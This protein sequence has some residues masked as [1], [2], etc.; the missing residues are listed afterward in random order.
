[1]LSL[2]AGAAS[3][4]FR[5]YIDLLKEGRL[6][7]AVRCWDFSAV[8]SKVSLFP[9]FIVAALFVLSF[10]FSWRGF[11]LVAFLR[12]VMESSKLLILF[13]VSIVIFGFVLR[14]SL[15]YG[16]LRF[17]AG[18]DRTILTGRK[19]RIIAEEDRGDVVAVRYVLGNTAVYEALLKKD[20]DSFKILQSKRFVGRYK[21]GTEPS[22]KER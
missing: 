15:T 2:L 6:G 1:M 8:S 13:V 12:R 18:A 20:G 16:A 22:D 14:F 3:D 17:M 11:F 10:I 21:N 19:V 4:F 7:D 9:I 5:F